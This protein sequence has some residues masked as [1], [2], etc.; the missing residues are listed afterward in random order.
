MNRLEIAGKQGDWKEDWSLNQIWFF[1]EKKNKNGQE[2]WKKIIQT[3]DVACSKIGH[4]V[5]TIW[6]TILTQITRFSIY[7]CSSV[8]QN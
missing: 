7:L 3:I 8:K 1:S 6:P 2:I 4:F 5:E